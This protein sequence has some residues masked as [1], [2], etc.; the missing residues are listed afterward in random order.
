MR[1]PVGRLATIAVAGGMVRLTAGFR[2][3]RTATCLLI[4]TSAPSR[5]TVA[6]SLSLPE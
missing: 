5:Y 3:D 1:K 4:A 6:D 2:A